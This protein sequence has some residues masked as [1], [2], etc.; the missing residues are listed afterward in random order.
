MKERRKRR[1]LFVEKEKNYLL[2]DAPLMN[3]PGAF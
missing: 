3:F 2:C 1:E